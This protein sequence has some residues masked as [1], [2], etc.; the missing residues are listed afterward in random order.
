M[1]DKT[2][3]YNQLPKL[4]PQADEGILKTT[5]SKSKEKVYYFDKFLKL[6]E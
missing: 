4:P 5:E 2:L 6:L 1:T 3:P